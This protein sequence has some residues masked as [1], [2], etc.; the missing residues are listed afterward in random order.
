MTSKQ[1]GFTLIE[2]VVYAAL[3]SVVGGIVLGLMIPMYKA[4]A[5]A[6]ISRRINTSGALMM[7][8]LMRETKDAESIKTASSTFATHPGV[9]VLNSTN[10]SSTGGTLK[11]SL[12]GGRGILTYGDGS[13]QF[14]T[15][16]QTEISELKFWRLVSTTSEGVRVKLTISDTSAGST[17]RVRTFYGS[18][19]LRGSYIAK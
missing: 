2:L 10:A 17:T 1:R 4:G 14:L 7:E 18:A 8:R 19:I 6:R 3:V 9:F 5:E 15:S 12:S 13:S 16:S 11:F